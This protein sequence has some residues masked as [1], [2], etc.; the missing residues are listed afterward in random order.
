MLCSEV[1]LE[2]PFKLMHPKPDI[3][4][5]WTTIKQDL[6]T[7]SVQSTIN[8]LFVSSGVRVFAAG[9]EGEVNLSQLD[10]VSFSTESLPGSKTERKQ[11]NIILPHFIIN[12][13]I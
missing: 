10:P 5:T 1:G 3:G 8:P 9:S 13:I 2:V 6:L 4:K 12:K 7:G 11:E